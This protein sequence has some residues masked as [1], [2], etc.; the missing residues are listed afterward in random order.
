MKQSLSWRFNIAAVS[1]VTVILLIFGVYDYQST[2]KSLNKRM[3][4]DI[5][6]LIDSLQNTLPA[7]LWNYQIEQLKLSAL[8]AVNNTNII[9][10][11][12]QEGGVTTIGY[13]RHALGEIEEISEP[14]QIEYPLSTP[15]VYDDEGSLNEVGVL[16]VSKNTIYIDEQKK[17]AVGATI[18]KIVVLDIL[19]AISL[20]LL[21]KQ[22]VSQPLDDIAGALK[23]IASG[24]GDLTQRIEIKRNDEIGR[25]AGYFNTFVE[26]I[27]IAMS[28]VDAS[29]QDMDS[30]VQA[31]KKHAIEN[32]DAVEKAH[33]ETDQVVTAI[34]EMSA[35]S[36]EVA[37]NAQ[38]VAT[39][40]HDADSETKNTLEIVNS[41]SKSIESLASEIQ[42]GAGVMSSLQDDVSNIVGVLETIRGIAEQTNL[43]AL[44][45][46]IEA[47]RAGE[48]GRGFAVVADEVRA[49][50]GRTQQSTSE[51]QG[52]I[53]T[54]EKGSS[55]AVEVME[56]STSK[57]TQTVEQ[58]ST[59][60]VSLGVIGTSITTINDMST[61]IA[62]SIEE[63]THVAEEI[64]INVTNIAGAIQT[65]ADSAKQTADASEN[66]AENASSLTKMVGQF[67]I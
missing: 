12:V 46:A 3:D 1:I 13:K 47:A 6:V 66:M 65:S 29:A 52:M 31:V 18:L 37:T 50:A 36:H 62:S 40:A 25:L 20:Q 8:S 30:S 11:M 53:D 57:S 63:Q 60:L 56:Q 19:V 43:L 34:T 22:L 67:K 33:S 10:I 26:K 45:A 14:S 4:Q 9:D 54:L 21:V 55:Q 64:N 24:E 38:E 32:A 41:T 58:I 39:A 42:S 35:T 59:A 17:N 28:Q 51:I 27:H 44:N 15:L 48:Q 16:I 49:L 2:S 7:S 61:Q 5:S 23:D